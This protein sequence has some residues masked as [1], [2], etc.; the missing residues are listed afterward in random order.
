[1]AVNN[2]KRKG[3]DIDEQAL[4]KISSIPEPYAS[5]KTIPVDLTQLDE[6]IRDIVELS[7]SIATTQTIDLPSMA[8]ALIEVK[9]HYLWFC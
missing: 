9:C 7:T 3:Y 2:A 6:M 5:Q 1:M 4:D 8:R